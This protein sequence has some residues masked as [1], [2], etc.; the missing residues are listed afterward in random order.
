MVV[1]FCTG[2]YDI[3]GSKHKCTARNELREKALLPYM[4]KKYK[5]TD[6][7]IQGIDWAGHKQ[8][9][10]SWT[11]AHRQESLPKSPSM[12]LHNFLHGWLTTGKMVARNNAALYPRECQ[13]CQHPVEDQIHFSKVQCQI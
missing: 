7:T 3:A 11:Y 12:F 13:S 2:F 5:W 6:I 4:Q 9:V 1:N 8:V 10:S